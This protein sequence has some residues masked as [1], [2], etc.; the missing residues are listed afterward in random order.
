MLRL[1][2]RAPKDLRLPLPPSLALPASLGMMRLAVLLPADLRGLW[3]STASLLLLLTATSV[4]L[5][6]AEGTCRQQEG[7]V[8]GTGCTH[9][10]IMCSAL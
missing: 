9:A 2:Q 8:R 1:L 5:Q 7:A 4:S 3:D 10:G 6:E